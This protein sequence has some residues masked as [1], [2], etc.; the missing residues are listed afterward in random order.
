MKI[1]ASGATVFARQRAIAA[2]AFA[3][4]LAVGSAA[5]APVAVI[6]SVGTRVELAAPARRIVSL[7]PHATELLFAAG[8]GSQVIG[9]IGTVQD[10]TEQR[11]TEHKLIQAQKME[12]VGNLTGGIAHDFNNLLTVIL[13]NCTELAGTLAASRSGTSERSPS[14]LTVPCTPSRSICAS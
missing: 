6:D 11:L 8:A 12:A 14:S 10:A 4:T 3:L 13:G 1:E 2:T 5:A 9:V 7:V